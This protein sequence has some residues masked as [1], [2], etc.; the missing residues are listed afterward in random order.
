MK[1]KLIEAAEKINSAINSGNEVFA[2][3]DDFAVQIV[4]AKHETREDGEHLLAYDAGDKEYCI[5][6]AVVR[7]EQPDVILWN[8]GQTIV[9]FCKE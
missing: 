6:G 4:S 3:W 7:Y 5:G 2:S 8:A 9:T 1:E